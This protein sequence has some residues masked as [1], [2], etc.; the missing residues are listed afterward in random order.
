MVYT[1]AFAAVNAGTRMLLLRN[2][3]SP[4][5]CNGMDV[6]VCAVMLNM[7]LNSTS[8]ASNIQHHQRRRRQIYMSAI[9]TSTKIDAEIF[10]TKNS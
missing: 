8:P 5:M 6:C 1:L 4:C 2:V 3:L 10:E 9:E 7:A